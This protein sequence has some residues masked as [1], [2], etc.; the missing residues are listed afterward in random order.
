MGINYGSGGWFW[1]L[2]WWWIAGGGGGGWFYLWVKRERDREE[3]R[4]IAMGE[5]RNGEEER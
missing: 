2:W 4:E 3:D 5:E 1:M